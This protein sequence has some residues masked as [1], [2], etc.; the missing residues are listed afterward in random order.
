VAFDAELRQRVTLLAEHMHAL[1]AAGC[2]PAP[3]AGN[4][5]EGCSMKTICAPH[6]IT[7]GNA[8]R[9]LQQSIAL[10]LAQE[11]DSA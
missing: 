3:I 8:R 2:T 11:R 6:T 9:Y 5:C 1:F 4:K 7:N 10:N